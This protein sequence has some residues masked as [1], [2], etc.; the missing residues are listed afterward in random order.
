MGSELHQ[1]SRLYEVLAPGHP[2]SY[3]VRLDEFRW[4]PS[5]GELAH[6][7]R[8]L[9]RRGART[10]VLDVARVSKVDA[11][12]IGELVRAYNVAVAGNGVLRIVNTNPWVRELLERVGLFGRLHAGAIPVDAAATTTCCHR[13]IVGG[14]C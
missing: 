2:Y 8:T 1:L 9:F 3:T 5:N 12:G 7:V 14:V 11:A 6:L 10:I 13:V 4:L